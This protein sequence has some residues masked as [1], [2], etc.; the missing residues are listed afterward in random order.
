MSNHGG[1]PTSRSATSP[2]TKDFDPHPN[3]D[4]GPSLDDSAVTGATDDDGEIEEDNSALEDLA[5]PLDLTFEEKLKLATKNLRPKKVN[6]KVNK[7]W[8]PEGRLKKIIVKKRISTVKELAQRAKQ[9]LQAQARKDASGNNGAEDHVTPHPAV[10][11]LESPEEKLQRAK[12]KLLNLASMQKGLLNSRNMAAM[13]SKKAAE[14]AAAAEAEAAAA[15]AAE[16]GEEDDGKTHLWDVL[17]ALKTKKRSDMY[18]EAM[19]M[20]ESSKN[21]KPG[22]R[23]WPPWLH[24]YSK[25]RTTQARNARFLHKQTIKAARDPDKE[26]VLADLVKKKKTLHLPKISYENWTKHVP[27]PAIGKRDWSVALNRREPGDY[28]RLD[29]LGWS[30]EDGY[31]NILKSPVADAHMKEVLEIL[32]PFLVP[33]S[34]DGDKKL[35]AGEKVKVF[36]LGCGSGEHAVAVCEKNKDVIW[37]PTDSTKICVASTTARSKFFKLLKNNEPKYQFG[38]LYEAQHFEILNYE[39]ALESEFLDSKWRSVDLL[40]AMNVVQYA[41]YRFMENMFRFANEIVKVFGCVFLYGPFRVEGELT[42]EQEMINLNL[43]K[44]SAKFG[45]RDLEDIVTIAQGFMFQLDLQF[46]MK[47]DMLGLV[48]KKTPKEV[49]VEIKVE[50]KVEEETSEKVDRSERKSMSGRLKDRM[51]SVKNVGSFFK[52]SGMNMFS[53]LGGKK[54]EDAVD[55][56]EAAR[57][58]AEGGIDDESSA[59]GS[60]AKSPK[61]E[62]RKTAAKRNP[63]RSKAANKAGDGSSDEDEGSPKRGARASR[64]TARQTK[65]PRKGRKSMQNKG[66]G[67]EGEGSEG[68]RGDRASRSP[69]R[70][71]QRGE[72]KS[73]MSKADNKQKSQ[74]NEKAAQASAEA[75]AEAA[76]A[77]FG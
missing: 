43:G 71:S 61:R 17:F 49:K 77:K 32:T 70:A 65:N 15:A 50:E 47:D 57:M 54:K 7:T 8:A 12:S 66:G 48:F 34:K 35:A 52:K 59:D 72:R 9:D 38:N 24:E 63:R 39:K 74:M 37:M 19:M 42:R 1:S 16:E 46:K 62:E 11:D 73:R 75:L 30:K 14:D 53:T 22:L 41:P 2:P 21:K 44:Q 68:E 28:F 69:N 40:V 51:K 36:E 64:A 18:A 25:P 6:A 29:S 23:D 10:A 67:G 56:A 13:A 26:D 31:I 33:A 45:I 27:M 60:A 3:L 20:V 5:K 4:G 76:M 55:A 58:E